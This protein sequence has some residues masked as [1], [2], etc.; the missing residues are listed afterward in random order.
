M[1]SRVSLRRCALTNRVRAVLDLCVLKER[2]CAA[3]EQVYS[4]V[5]SESVLLHTSAGASGSSSRSAFGVGL[6][7]R[8]SS[9]GRRACRSPRRNA[10]G[11]PRPRL[12]R[13]PRAVPDP[14]PRPREDREWD[15][16]VAREV[17]HQEVIEATFDRAEAYARLG[18]FG[19]AVDGSIGRRRPAG[20]CRP[21]I[22]RGAHVGPGTH[23]SASDDAVASVASRSTPAAPARTSR[24]FSEGSWRSLR[25]SASSAD[26]P[27]RTR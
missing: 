24:R 2:R 4:V 25:R 14:P 8:G 15:G 5:R 16:L 9:S 1:F 12:A 3:F 10:R 20:T 21:R 6:S 22:A 27:E 26:R 17:R 18:D 7:Q 23:R 11:A 13:R 19:R